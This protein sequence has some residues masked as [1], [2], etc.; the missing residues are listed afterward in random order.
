MLTVTFEGNAMFLSSP[1]IIFTAAVTLLAVLIGFFTVIRVANTRRRTG[2]NAPIMIG[3]PDLECALRV[4]G[5]TVEQFVIFLPSLWLAALYFQG[6][7]APAIGLVWCVGRLIYIA[8]YSAAK[9][10]GRYPGFALTVLPTVIL[11]VLALMG[12][13]GAWGATR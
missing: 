5:N 8:G 7:W 4:Q 11:F 3:H 9:P 12:L 1:A 6:W 2:L 13:I 10:T